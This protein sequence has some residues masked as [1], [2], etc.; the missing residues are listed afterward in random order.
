MQSEAEREQRRVDRLI[1]RQLRED[2][3]NLK[4][5]LKLLLLG[6]LTIVV[7][8]IVNLNGVLYKHWSVFQTHEVTIDTIRLH[9]VTYQIIFVELFETSDKIGDNLILVTTRCFSLIVKNY[10][11]SINRQF[12]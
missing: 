9:C 1:T 6:V 8:C 3:R 2:K 12:C 7:K 4:H 11:V 10:F 5:E